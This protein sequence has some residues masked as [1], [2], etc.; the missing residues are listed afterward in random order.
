MKTYKTIDDAIYEVANEQVVRRRRNPAAAMIVLI[1]GLA[2][3]GLGYF[4][5][6]ALNPA[7][8]SGMILSGFVLAFA[9]MVKT[10][11]DLSDKGRP[12][13][14]PSG[15][16]LRRYELIF[17][18]PYRLKV[19]QCVND[20]DL[21]ALT[22]LPHGRSASVVAVIYKTAHNDVAMTQV[23][24]REPRKRR[25]LTEMKMFEKGQFILTERLV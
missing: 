10:I 7:L 6:N 24:D 21:D 12:Y 4:A 19:C 20:G 18:T 11:I 3:M 5:A 9:G 17:D 16:K 25:P 23:F 2:V 15:E 8:A 22:G 1:M 13:Y 14:K